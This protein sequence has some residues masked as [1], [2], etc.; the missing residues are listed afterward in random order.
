MRA[1]SAC[2]DS[3]PLL[4]VADEDRFVTHEASMSSLLDGLN[5]VLNQRIRTDALDVFMAQ[6]SETDS[7]GW[8]GAGDSRS[9]WIENHL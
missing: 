6:L 1:A 5:H 7:S 3:H 2:T 4:D 9:P 8:F